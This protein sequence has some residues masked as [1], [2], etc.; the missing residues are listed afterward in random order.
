MITQ[1]S[2]V[3]LFIGDVVGRPGR[4][5]LAEHL[6]LW[7]EEWKVDF[8]I[9]NGENAAGG[10]GLTL[11]TVKKFR[12]YGVD[13]ITSGNHVLDRKDEI[14]A[15]LLE[16]MVLR[17]ENYVDVPGRGVWRG[18]I[19]GVSAMVFN[20]EGA[21]FMEEEP[22]RSNPFTKALEIVEASQE[23][24]KILDFHAETTSEKVA[25]GW[26]LDGRVS[27]VLGTHTHIQTADE[28][29]LPKGTLYITDVGMTGPFDS[30]I[31]MDKGCIIKRF[32]TGEQERMKIANGDLRMNA[33][34]LEID[35]ETGRGRSIRR[36]VFGKDT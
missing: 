17:P 30:V 7:R 26:L 33:V 14:P 22:K 3:V 28:R 5:I 6:R 4:R 32:L 29:V 2:V 24:I 23:V 31:G 35:K 11:N 19:A 36:L 34:L 25:M 21:V 20:L 15:V 18:E 13:L 12:R 16:D 1:N 10:F 9:V 8:V 27:A